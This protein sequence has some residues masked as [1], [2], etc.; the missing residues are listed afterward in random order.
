MSHGA[1]DIKIHPSIVGWI[2]TWIFV[3][4]FINM[5]PYHG[6]VC[7]NGQLYICQSSGKRKHWNLFI[8]IYVSLNVVHMIIEIDLWSWHSSVCEC[9]TLKYSTLNSVLTPNF[10]LRKIFLLDFDDVSHKTKTLELFYF[11]ICYYPRAVLSYEMLRL[12]VA[13]F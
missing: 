9:S 7:R 5:A 11:L 6:R 12:W 2:Q 4:A 3:L 13:L 8:L 1:F 10:F